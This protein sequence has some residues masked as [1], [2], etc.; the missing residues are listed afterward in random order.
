MAAK[1]GD[2]YPNVATIEVIESAANTLTY[3]KLE[4]GVSMMEKVAW[5]IHRIEYWL[6]INTATFN[7]NGDTLVVAL[8]NSNIFATLHADATFAD[9]AMIDSVLV[10]RCDV[11]TP[12]VTWMDFA[13]ITKDFSNLPGGGLLVPPIPVFGAAQGVGLNAATTNLIK[14][15]Y[16][17][18]EL[19]TEDYWQLV[20]A[21]RTLSA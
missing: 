9:A 21:K 20:E 16:T 19:A 18:K 1:N 17:I 11:G 6:D 4:A 12:A 13:P 10:R 5:L 2:S 8:L 14:I 7:S 15:W 3:K